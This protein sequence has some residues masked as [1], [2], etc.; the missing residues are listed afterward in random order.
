MRIAGKFFGKIA[1]GMCLEHMYR[2]EM[3]S[4]EFKWYVKVLEIH[5]D[6]NEV[7]MMMINN[8]GNRYTTIWDLAHTQSGL[9]RGEYLEILDENK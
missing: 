1:P 9:E 6:R 2:R 5:K 8:R 4:A 7:T 3:S